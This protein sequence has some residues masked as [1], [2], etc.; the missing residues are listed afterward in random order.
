MARFVSSLDAAEEVFNEIMFMKGQTPGTS[1]KIRPFFATK[2]IR[3]SIKHF[4]ADPIMIQL[5]APC[6]VVG[7][8]FGDL[9]DLL[10]IFETYGY[11]PNRK[12]VFLGDVVGSFPQSPETIILLCS[13]KIQFPTYLYVIRGY[14]E[15]RDVNKNSTFC[16]ESIN[17]FGPEFYECCNELFDDL[18]LL[19]Q[20]SEK[21]LCVSSGVPADVAYLDQ[22]ASLTRPLEPSKTPFVKEMLSLQPDVATNEWEINKKSTHPL[23]KLDF[24]HEFTDRNNLEVIIRSHN[25]VK[26]GYEFPFDGDPKLLTISTKPSYLFKNFEGKPVEKCGIILEIETSLKSLFRTIHPLPYEYKEYYMSKSERAKLK[27]A[28]ADI[29]RR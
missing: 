15:M 27:K 28:E 24:I 4:L 5:D 29:L 9:Y 13:L 11:P 19:C 7:G 8:L 25:V 14:H 6:I 2:V 3:D 17:R 22:F 18:P 10:L 26:D 12:Y 1:S 16:T 21:M 20:I 23:M